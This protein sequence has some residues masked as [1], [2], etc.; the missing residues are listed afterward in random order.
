[1]RGDNKDA[2]FSGSATVPECGHNKQAREA[3]AGQVSP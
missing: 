3:Q 1:M 2:I